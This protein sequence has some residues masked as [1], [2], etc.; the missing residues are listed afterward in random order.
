MTAFQTFCHLC[1][2]GFPTRRFGVEW[3]RPDGD[4]RAVSRGDG[5]AVSDPR[6]PPLRSTTQTG[7]DG[8]D[9]GRAALCDDAIGESNARAAP[10]VAATSIPSNE[11]VKQAQR[12][13]GRLTPLRQLSLPDDPSQ[14]L[15]RFEVLHMGPG[16][17]RKR[18]PAP[19]AIVAVQSDAGRAE[20]FGLAACAG[21]LGDV[22]A[23]VPAC[24]AYAVGA[25]VFFVQCDAGEMQIADSPGANRKRPR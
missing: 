23:G 13:S 5:N 8:S 24:L 11:T 19:C 7:S 16:C 20:G 22:P 3:S 18:P 21:C 1:R 2:A 10:S 4:A 17:S 9:Q 25:D 6:P 12:W 15:M 14:P